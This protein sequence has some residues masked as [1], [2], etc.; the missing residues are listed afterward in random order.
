MNV[1]RELPPHRTRRISLTKTQ[2]RTELGAE[3][4]S[5]C[6]SN[7]TDGKLE[8]LE[9]EALRE[10]LDE[11]ADAELPAASY[12]REVVERVLEDGTITPDEC[13]EVYRAI[14]AVLPPE[15]R[16]QATT[17]RKE[18]E[19][20]EK[21]E[22]KVERE[23][24]RQREERQRNRP[25]ASAN[26]M[27][28]GVRYEGRPEI[29]SRYAA[30]NDS[31]RLTRDHGNRHS[32]NAIAVLLESNQQIG[33]VPETW[34]EGLAPLLDGGAKYS[35]YITKILGSGRSPIPVVQT[36]FYRPDSMLHVS[37]TLQRSTSST[38]LP[39]EQQ[40]SSSRLWLWL[41]LAVGAGVL[42]AALAWD[43]AAVVATWQVA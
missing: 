14:E 34:A 9:A 16:R 1:Q 25:I 21:S 7:T 5:L 12:L 8:P 6:E 35:A 17:A 40:R 18:V 19:A 23:R 33:F 24:A 11:S 28:A 39:H 26:F 10:W 27:V 13:R 3:L 4:L 41:L 32:S 31:V 15:L 29:I 43:L 20:A 37:H 38:M 22:A 42:I 30:V 2:L 36:R